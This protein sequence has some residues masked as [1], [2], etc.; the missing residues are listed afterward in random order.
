MSDKQEKK[1]QEIKQENKSPLVF[2]G[3]VFCSRKEL[4]LFIIN[5]EGDKLKDVVTEEIKQLEN[6]VRFIDVLLGKEKISIEP[7]IL[8]DLR[9]FFRIRKQIGYNRNQEYDFSPFADDGLL[10]HLSV[11]KNIQNKKDKRDEL[12]KF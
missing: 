9:Q 5:K 11:F 3:Q 8:S 2:L 7:E 4:R 12:T 1:E 10:Y 6:E